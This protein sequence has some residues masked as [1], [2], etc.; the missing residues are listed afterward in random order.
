MSGAGN[1]LNKEGGKTK[2]K[3]SN[4]LQVLACYCWDFGINA[5]KPS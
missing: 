2:Q 3:K 5:K 4:T 1:Y